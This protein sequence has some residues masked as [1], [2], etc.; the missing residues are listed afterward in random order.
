MG[1]YNFE[2]VRE[3]TY[4]GDSINDENKIEEEIQKRIV[5]GNPAY[6][7]HLVIPK[8]RPRPRRGR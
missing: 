3:F 6:F 1:S 7:S 8:V 4:L 2:S 5:N